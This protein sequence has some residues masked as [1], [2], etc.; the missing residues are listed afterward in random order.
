MEPLTDLETFK[1]L[2]LAMAAGLILG[3]E[4]EHANKPAGV[5]TF[6]LVCEGAAL[7]MLCALLLS[8]QL[9]AANR[10]SDPG[11]MASTVIQGIGFIA[12]GVILTRGSQVVGLTTAAGVWV[13]AA[14]GLLFGAGF[15]ELGIAATVVTVISLY[16]LREVEVRFGRAGAPANSG[17][18][19]GAGG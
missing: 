12:A 3:L 5:R 8:D 1:R 13:T 18:D 6:M 17:R 2:G 19:D 7:F 14:I 10:I 4:R 9:A 16:V 11:R 15:I